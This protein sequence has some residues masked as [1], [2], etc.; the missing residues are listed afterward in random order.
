M[1]V[2]EENLTREEILERFKKIFGREM[3]PRERLAFFL[4]PDTTQPEQKN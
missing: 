2:P 1:D 3:T 4:A